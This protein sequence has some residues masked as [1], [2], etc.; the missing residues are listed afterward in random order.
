MDDCCPKFFSCLGRGP[1]FDDEIF[2]SVAV[3]FVLGLYGDDGKIVKNDLGGERLCFASDFF[4]LAWRGEGRLRRTYVTYYL[5]SMGGMGKGFFFFYALEFFFL[6]VERGRKVA[7]YV[8]DVLS[9]FDG[10]D[11]LY[12]KSLRLTLTV[13]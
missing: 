13:M 1:R 11:G 6:G 3:A 2:F 8:R 4:F 7:T 12:N 5:G 9:R 10:W